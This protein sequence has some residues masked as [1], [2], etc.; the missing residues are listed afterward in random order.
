VIDNYAF[1]NGDTYD[2]FN[3][4]T[5]DMSNFNVSVLE[6]AL[7]SLANNPD[8]FWNVSQF[9]LD[10]TVSVST[11]PEPSAGAML[12]TGIASLGFLNALKRNKK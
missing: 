9:T 1:A 7:P 2:L 12:V 5:A 8:L 11:V 4:G 3:W 6:A 10:G